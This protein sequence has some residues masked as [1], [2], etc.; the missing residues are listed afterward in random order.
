MNV[1]IMTD[2]RKLL[3]DIVASYRPSEIIS[4]LSN[5]ELIFFLVYLR[6]TLWDCVM[7]M[8]VKPGADW[9]ATCR[10]AIH[11]ADA[12]DPRVLGWLYLQ[13]GDER[14]F[15]SLIKTRIDLETLDLELMKRLEQRKAGWKLARMLKKGLAP[16]ES[17]IDDLFQ[18]LGVARIASDDPGKDDLQ[19]Q[20]A[21]MALEFREEMGQKA[22]VG[23]GLERLRRLPIKD[24]PGSGLPALPREWTEKNESVVARQIRQ[25]TDLLLPVLQGEVEQIP[26]A[27]QQSIETHKETEQR[28][29]RR[30]RALL[31]KREINARNKILG[32][33]EENQ[34]EQ[35]LA[36]KRAKEDLVVTAG[37]RWGD[38]AAKAVEYVVIH[39]KKEKEAASLADVPYDSLRRYISKL[40]KH[41]N[42]YR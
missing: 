34:L 8:I 41:F 30:Q 19:G 2:L 18:L 22:L 17:S 31:H 32:T 24:Q 33:H 9:G 20:A 12:P 38:K 26:E 14:L 10:E 1:F 11:V 21:V 4:Q 39:G 15:E 27:V 3:S 6:A 29:A 25:L 23:T 16:M 35:R 37:A 28:G 5:E 40:Y 7:R 36:D 42:L 13:S